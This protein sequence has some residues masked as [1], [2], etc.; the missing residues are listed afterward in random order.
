VDK[1]SVTN[2]DLKQYKVSLKMTNAHLEGYKPDANMHT[3]KGNKF[4]DVISKLFP[5]GPD[6]GVEVALRREWITYK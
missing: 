1:E 4:R 2:A 5:G 6:S 3:S